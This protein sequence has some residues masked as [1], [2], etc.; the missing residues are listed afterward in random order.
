MKSLLKKI[1]LNRQHQSGFRVFRLKPV[2]RPAGRVLISMG[3]L[4]YS[5]LRDGLPIRTLHP[6][7]WKNWNLA[8]TFLDLG[9]QIDA[10]PSDAQP[11]FAGKSFDVVIDVRSNLQ[12]L[13][14]VLASHGTRIMFPQ[15]CHWALHNGGQL[16]RYQN[17]LL[18]S[19]IALQPSRL[20]SYTDSVE[21]A[22]RIVTPGSAF[23]TR[24]FS[25]TGAAIYH[26]NQA[27]PN[28]TMQFVKRDFDSARKHFLWISGSGA[29]HKGLDLLLEAFSQRP[30]LHL[31][32]CGDISSEQPFTRAFDHLLRERTNVHL[33]GWMDTQTES[34]LELCRRCAFVVLHSASEVTATSPIAGMYT[35]M[36][37]IVNE[38]ADQATMDFGC[39]LR[40]A[41]VGE[42][43]D[44]LDRMSSASTQELEQQSQASFDHA[45]HRY[46]QS[47][48][49]LS[50]RSA[51][52]QALGISREPEWDLM[53]RPGAVPNRLPVIDDVTREYAG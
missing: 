23:S 16:Q 4:V 51:M 36:I 47:G 37:P 44:A 7:A 9:F 38:G 49:M 3:S 40:Q 15:F 1:G 29:V 5:E 53:D 30:E 17:L 26:I 14:E 41:T 18:R 25:H 31:H 39:L 8:R 35:G 45:A 46:T 34:W 2:N 12:H 28:A 13:S 48:F 52:C 33:H 50:L 19:G 20:I 27:P 10:A 6:A 11:L 22:D 42:L 24:G 21:C 32:I 43:L